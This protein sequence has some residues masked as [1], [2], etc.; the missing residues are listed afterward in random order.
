MA[1]VL[2]TLGDIELQ[3]LTLPSS[4]NLSAD[5]NYVEHDKIKGKPTL[6]KVGGN[7]RTIALD[8][9]FH[10]GWCDPEAE[11]Q[12]LLEADKSEKP[13]P[14]VLGEEFLD[15]WVIISLTKSYARLQPDASIWWIDVTARLKEYVGT[16]VA[17]N[18]AGEGSGFV[19]NSVVE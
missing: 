11:Y 9:R 4:L 1:D 7:L 13:L 2:A 17:G 12:K 3:L 18:E 14:L 5:F 10:V 16:E 8:F 15:E 6:Q 19:R